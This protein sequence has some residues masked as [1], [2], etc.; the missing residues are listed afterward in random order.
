MC[1]PSAV[2]TQKVNKTCGEIRSGKM[3]NYSVGRAGMNYCQWNGQTW[4]RQIIP[5]HAPPLAAQ[6]LYPFDSFRSRQRFRSIDSHDDFT[7]QQ[8]QRK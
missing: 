2:Q 8:R 7:F 5:R 6:G 1:F 4:F 3:E